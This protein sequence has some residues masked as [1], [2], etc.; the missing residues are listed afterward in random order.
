VGRKRR[1]VERR[2]KVCLGDSSLKGAG[3][4]QTGLSRETK[5]KGERTIHYGKG[6]KCPSLK[7]ESALRGNFPLQSRRGGGGG[8]IKVPSYTDGGKAYSLRRKKY[9]FLKELRK[10][11]R[12]RAAKTLNRPLTEEERWGTLFPFREGGKG[13]H[14]K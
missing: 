2:L 9:N 13:P 14:E 6:G 4:R 1:R 3:E 8:K 11:L 12:Q 10:P 7:K 5:T